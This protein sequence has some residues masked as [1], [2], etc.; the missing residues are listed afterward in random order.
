MPQMGVSVAEGTVTAWLKSPGDEVAADETI[1]E[2]TT[3]KIDVEI[4]APAS[5]VLIE[6]LVE[7]GE[8]V[9]VGTVLAKLGQAAGTEEE[10]AP[11]PEAPSAPE[12]SPSSEI[13]RSKFHSPVVLR[14]AGEHGIDLDQVEGHGVGGRVRKADLLALIEQGPIQPQKPERPL[15]SESP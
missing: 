9:E 1:A 15:H 6:V 12:A 8:T 3:D 5:G 2:V 7:E 14:I 10:T 4:P 13:D 11:E